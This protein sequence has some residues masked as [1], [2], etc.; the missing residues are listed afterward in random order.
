MARNG[1]NSVSSRLRSL[2]NY[3][4]IA[5]FCLYTFCLPH[6][7]SQEHLTSFKGCLIPGKWEPPKENTVTHPANIDNNMENCNGADAL[8]TQCYEKVLGHERGVTT[9]P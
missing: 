8:G 7:L 1:S 9:L 5:C 2:T 4:S 6:S 3:W